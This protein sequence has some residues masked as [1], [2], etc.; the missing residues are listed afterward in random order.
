[1]TVYVFFL[2]A[3]IFPAR[4]KGESGGAEKC[5]RSRI[6]KYA[7]GVKS[8]GHIRSSRFPPNSTCNSYKA[9]GPAVRPEQLPTNV[10]LSPSS[11]HFRGEGHEEGH[12]D[13]RVDGFRVQVPVQ[14]PADGVHP[15]PDAAGA[16][17]FTDEPRGVDGAVTLA[18]LV[19]RVLV[20]GVLGPG[21]HLNQFV[22]VGNDEFAVV[23]HLARADSHE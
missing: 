3:K 20:S 11:P 9:S 7:E 23:V 12:L 14:V 22:V 1:M 6:Q 13:G 15:G 10:I 18:G 4:G 8:A 2:V 16:V 19:E 17:L 5:L 21:F